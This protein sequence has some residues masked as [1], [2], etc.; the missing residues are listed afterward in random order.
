MTHVTYTTPRHIEAM[1]NRAAW[2]APYGWAD[3]PRKRQRYDRMDVGRMVREAK[4]TAGD[5]NIAAGLHRIPQ[6]GPGRPKGIGAERL[7]RMNAM[8]DLI[9]REGPMGRQRIAKALGIAPNTVNDYARLLMNEGLLGVSRQFV[10]QGKPA[11][12]WHAVQEA[13]E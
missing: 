4:Q 10:G 9:R 1:H 2:K 8:L 7:E 5:E 6:I 13:A 3:L 11:S 12:I